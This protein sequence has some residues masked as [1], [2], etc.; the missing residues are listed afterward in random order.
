M[1]LL[2]Y[3]FWGIHT[4]TRTHTHTHTHKRTYTHAHT[5]PTLCIK[6][7]LRNQAHIW[8][9]GHNFYMLSIL[10][11]IQAIN[12]LH[13]RIM[14]ATCSREGQILEKKYFHK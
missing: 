8:L 14:N 6:V 9:A 13:E 12:A 7:I 10:L 11:N 3:A 5:V 4:H 2:I 1:P